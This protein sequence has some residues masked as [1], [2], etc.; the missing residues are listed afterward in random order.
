MP[1]R[2]K[3]Q[4][5]SIAKNAAAFTSSAPATSTIGVKGN[6]GG[7]RLNAARTP[8]RV[9]R[10]IRFLA[11]ARYLDDAN[12]SS[13]ASPTLSPIQNV[14]SAPTT[15]PPVASSATAHQG[16]TPRIERTTVA[17]AIP[18]GSQKNSVESSAA[19]IRI[20]TGLANVVRA[21]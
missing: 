4:A 1:N 5:V 8:A 10:S 21:Q 9:F 17:A 3:R 20:P 19:R 13:P 14:A 16:A 15:D 18:N 2:A 12:R 6:G 11:E 7:M